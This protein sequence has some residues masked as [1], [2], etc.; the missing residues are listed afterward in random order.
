MSQSSIFVTDNGCEKCN[1]FDQSQ[2]TWL[3]LI[4]RLSICSSAYKDPLSAELLCSCMENSLAFRTLKRAEN[5]RSSN[6]QIIKELADD[7]E[8]LTLPGASTSGFAL[9]ASFKRTF[10]SFRTRSDKVRR[11][12]SL[13]VRGGVKMEAEG[14]ERIRWSGHSRS[15]TDVS[16]IVKGSADSPRVP[17]ARRKRLSAL[18]PVQ[19]QRDVQNDVVSEPQL[20]M[21]SDV[22]AGPSSST[23]GDV[24]VPQLLQLGTPM[25]KVS[26]KKH[27]RV[28]FRL[29]ADLGQIEWESKK[30]KISACCPSWII[31]RH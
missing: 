8:G 31:L 4:P 25:T 10:R 13:S 12:K 22:V 6:G 28:V 24:I 16:T 23:V 2:C 30:H 9:G 27:K 20:L 7:R 29:D 26:L 21:S 14:A 15:L 19:N 1:V 3:L 11:S 17:A 5:L 18:S